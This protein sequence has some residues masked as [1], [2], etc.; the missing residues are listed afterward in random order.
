MVEYNSKLGVFKEVD[1]EKCSE[2]I[3]FY[4]TN[5]VEKLQIIDSIV[6]RCIQNGVEEALSDPTELEDCDLPTKQRIQYQNSILKDGLQSVTIEELQTKE[7]IHTITFEYTNCCVSIGFVE[8]IAFTITNN[9]R[10]IHL[11]SLFPKMVEEV[12]FRR[13]L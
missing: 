9:T 6:H 1:E 8:T 12:G 4:N 11:Q 10:D 2:V 3:E 13:E 7:N 5:T